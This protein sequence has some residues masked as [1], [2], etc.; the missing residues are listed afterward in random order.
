MADFVSHYLFGELALDAF[1][2]TV[3]LAAARRPAAFNWGLMGP[4]PLFYHKVVLGRPL[5]KYGNKMHSERTDELFFAF[6]R[7]VGR[8]TGTGRAIAEAYFYGFLCH[9]AL[10]SALHPYVYCRQHELLQADP[11]LHPSSVHCQIESDIDYALYEREYH[12]PVTEFDPDKYF[13]LADEELAVLAVLLHYLLGTVYGVRVETAA[14]RGA[15]REML[16]VQNFVYSSSYGAYR[17]LRRAEQ[18]F[19][20]GALLTSHMKLE[21]PAWDCLN[22]GHAP[23]YSLWQPEAPRTDSVPELIAAAVHRV[24]GLA[25]QYAAEFDAGWLLLHHFDQP[26]DAGNLKGLP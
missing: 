10:D 16:V 18:L 8:M 13:K 5:H 14:L 20:R 23:W 17:G 3:Q 9:H 7:A 2:A 21:P 11:S 4:D 19:G 6:A 26:F 24:A 25:G 12:A 15:F 22:L 1:P